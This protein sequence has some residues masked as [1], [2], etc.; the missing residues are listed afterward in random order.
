MLCTCLALWCF[1]V[2]VT[3]REAREEIRMKK[4]ILRIKPRLVGA[5]SGSRTT[6]FHRNLLDSL[7]TKITVGLCRLTLLCIDVVRRCEEPGSFSDCMWMY[8]FTVFIV[9]LCCV[10][11][12]S[13]RVAHK[14]AEDISVCT[15]RIMFHWKKIYMYQYYKNN[16]SRVHEYTEARHLILYELY[17]W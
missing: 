3:L 5:L 6:Y 8:W 1:T 12:I 16:I 9:Q 14:L 4:N 17:V 7:V 13:C 2:F 10:I 11:A 15:N